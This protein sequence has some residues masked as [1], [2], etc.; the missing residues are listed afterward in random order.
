MSRVRLLSDTLAS[1]VAAGEVIE[2]PASVVKELVENS[3]DAGAR[4]IEVM[5]KRGG[6]SLIR[7]TDDG[8]GMD[9]DD[10]LLCLERHATSKIRTAADLAIVAT[11]GFRGEALPSIASVSRFRLTTREKEAVAG[12]EVLVAGGKI[13]TVRDGGEAPGTQVEVRSLFYNL[14]PRRKFLRSENTETRN[15]EHQLNLQAIGHPEIAFSL[16]RDERVVFQLPAT[17]TLRDRIRDLMGSE[18]VARLLEVE[19]GGGRLRVSGFIGQAGVSRASR[20]QQFVF[21]NGRAIESPVIG[22]ALKEGYHTALMKGQFP[23]TFLFVELDPAE[24]DVNVHPAKREVRFRDPNGVREA[25]VAAIRRT[26]ESDRK[27]WQEQ[28]RAPAPTDTTFVRPEEVVA[29]RFVPSPAEELQSRLPV[30]VEPPPVSARLSSPNEPSSTPSQFQILGVL[31]KLYV[32]MENV[33]GLVLVDQHA[34]HERILFEELR[35]R[36]EEHGVPSQRL[37]LPQ[38]IELAPRDAEWIERNLA[39]LQKMG[40]GVEEFGR[41][42]FKLESLPPFLSGADPARLLQDVID[43]L[44]SASHSTS[45]LR[46]G[47]DMIAKTVCRHAVKANDFLRAPEVEKLIRD[48]LTCELPY[49]C[50]HGRPTMIQISLGELEKKFGRKV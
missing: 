48:L 3:I 4:S 17:R 1:Q 10:A 18:L 46:L 34:A 20:A 19:P 15:I 25:V 28:F 22:A 26:L 42:T 24:V 5:I 8:S 50:P 37:L 43:S 45:P 11:L 47:E 35:R 36:M 32:L 31:N 49:C 9:R 12:T 23:V 40:L 14:P 21:V 13:E 2:R 41:H 6:I 7:V 30:E 39:T 16:V 38:V 33:E 27:S 29:P 44:K